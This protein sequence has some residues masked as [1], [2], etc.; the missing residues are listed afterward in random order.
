M[1][2]TISDDASHTISGYLKTI[3]VLKPRHK[4]NLGK[5][6]SKLHDKVLGIQMV[7]MNSEDQFNY[8]F[9][10]DQLGHGVK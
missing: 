6:I 5:A 7:G 4:G 3:K 2:R 9:I 8:E 10:P 1:N